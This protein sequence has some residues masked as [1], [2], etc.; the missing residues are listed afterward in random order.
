MQDKI[1]GHW[2]VIFCVQER[3]QPRLIFVGLPGRAIA[4]EFTPAGYGGN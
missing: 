3:L 1:T 4:N 2:P